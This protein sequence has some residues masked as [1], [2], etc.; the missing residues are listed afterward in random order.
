MF[1]GTGCEGGC[2]GWLVERDVYRVVLI[3]LAFVAGEEVRI[4]QSASVLCI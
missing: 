2:F 1:W 3:F 4:R